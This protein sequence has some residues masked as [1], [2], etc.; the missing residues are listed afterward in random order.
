VRRATRSLTQTYT[1]QDEEAPAK[2]YNKNELAALLELRGPAHSLLRPILFPKRA[3]VSS[4]ERHERLHPASSAWGMRGKGGKL[5]DQRQKTPKVK[6]TFASSPPLLARLFSVNPR[7]PSLVF[8]SRSRAGLQFGINYQTPPGIGET[9]W[10]G[11]LLH[12]ADGVVSVDLVWT[13]LRL[14]VVNNPWSDVIAVTAGSLNA[15][16]T[17]WP[18]LQSLGTNSLM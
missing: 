4:Y 6:W 10:R 1:K 14:P 3:A 17:V 2:W 13:L 16:H 7:L 5:R 11:G 18:R 9:A 8:H 12:G 15:I